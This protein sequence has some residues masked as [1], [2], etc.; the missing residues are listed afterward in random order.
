MKT[1][2]AWSNDDKR[3]LRRLKGAVERAAEICEGPMMDYYGNL[4]AGSKLGSWSKQLRT[5]AKS[6]ERDIEHIN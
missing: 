3:F 1:R 2:R 4:K 6:I 5:V